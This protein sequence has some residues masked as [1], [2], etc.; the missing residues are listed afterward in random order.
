METFIEVYTRDGGCFSAKLEAKEMLDRILVEPNG[1][2]EIPLITQSVLVI[3]ERMIFGYALATP[4]SRK[5]RYEFNY[6]CE[7]EEEEIKK[8][9]R[10]YED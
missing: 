3:K 9:L 6:K 10:L 8:S 2:V 4:E 5:A 1:V 7:Q